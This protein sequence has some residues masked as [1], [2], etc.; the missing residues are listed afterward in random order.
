MNRYISLG[1]AML[2][3][4]AI[5]AAAVGGLHAQSKPKAYLVTELQVLDAAATAAYGPKVQAT[6]KAVGGR[7][8]NTAGGRVT[9]LEGA[10][11]PQRVAITEWDSLEQ[12]Q[13]WN[14]SPARKNLLPER[15]KAEKL[16][17]AYVVEA[18]N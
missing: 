9:S 7:V 2:A 5:G 11:P 18:V 8:L 12:A 14:N 6:Q 10:P 13:A 16:I 4:A 1:I 3:G 17:R 15:D